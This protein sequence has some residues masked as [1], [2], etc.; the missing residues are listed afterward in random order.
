MIFFVDEMKDLMGIEERDWGVGKES[1][2]SDTRIL[3]RIPTSCTTN[4]PQ[5][6][7]HKL[8]LCSNS[9]DNPCLLRL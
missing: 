4:R 1:L 2:L 8:D 3:V 6:G 9:R 7:T 5:I